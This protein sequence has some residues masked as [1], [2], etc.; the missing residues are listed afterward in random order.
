LKLNKT[1][2]RMTANSLNEMLSNWSNEDIATLAGSVSTVETLHARMAAIHL[3]E[4]AGD[5]PI[6]VELNASERRL[7]STALQECLRDFGQ[8]DN[9][10]FPVHIGGWP[11]EAVRLVERLKQE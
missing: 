4:R 6:E 3:P 2:I 9:W 5:R 11:Q 7:I 8:R 10:D 1:E